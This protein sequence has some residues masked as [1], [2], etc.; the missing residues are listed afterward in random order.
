MGGQG[1]GEGEG[2]Y[3]H[4]KQPRLRMLPLEILIRERL[5][6]INTRRART[7][8]IQEVAALA[9][10]VFDLFY[11]AS[12]TCPANAHTH[13]QFSTLNLPKQKKKGGR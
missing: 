11:I 9:H 1:E 2:T 12:A 4:R 8:T 5:R 3:S 10:E 6:S 13:T 7:V